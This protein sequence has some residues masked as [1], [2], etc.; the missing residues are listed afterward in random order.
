MGLTLFLSLLVMKTFQVSWSWEPRSDP[1]FHNTALHTYIPFPGATCYVLQHP[2]VIFY[3]I[4]STGWM[5]LCGADNN[6]FCLS[7]SRPKFVPYQAQFFFCWQEQPLSSLEQGSWACVV[8]ENP[9]IITEQCLVALSSAW[10][11]LGGD[12]ESASDHNVNERHGCTYIKPH[13][14]WYTYNHTATLKNS[15]QWRIMF[16]FN[17]RGFVTSVSNYTCLQGCVG[18]VVWR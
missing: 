1:C 4:I 3:H 5:M 18:G 7:P 12:Y 13:L 11:V 15:V 10:E 2:T 14:S 6:V 16:P 9:A 17:G 8:Y